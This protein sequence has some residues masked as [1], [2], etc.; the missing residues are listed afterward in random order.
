MKKL[1]DKLNSGVDELENM[2]EEDKDSAAAEVYMRVQNFTRKYM[3]AIKQTI[4]SEEQIEASKGAFKS[5][6]NLRIQKEMDDSEASM[7]SIEI[8][9]W[10]DMSEEEAQQK[11]KESFDRLKRCIALGKMNFFITFM[12][13]PSDE[14]IERAK[15]ALEKARELQEKYSDEEIMER[16]NANLEDIEPDDKFIWEYGCSINSIKLFEQVMGEN[17]PEFDEVMGRK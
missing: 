11:T 5:L 16:I 17:Y 2:I 9:D 1:V 14:T 10:K 6:L 4:L 12:V 7:E 15:S 13:N 3:E 8:D